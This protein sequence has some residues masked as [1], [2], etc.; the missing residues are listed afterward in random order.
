MLFLYKRFK[1]N[2]MYAVKQKCCNIHKK[3]RKNADSIKPI[4]GEAPLVRNL[5]KS[6]K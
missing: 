4:R 2:K 6:F 1:I 3:T 5:Q